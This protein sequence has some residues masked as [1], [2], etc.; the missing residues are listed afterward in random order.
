MIKIAILVILV[1][2][3]FQWKISS[4]KIERM[5]I[6]NQSMDAVETRIMEN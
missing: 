5:E 3:A 4:D 1:V 6:M 2:Y